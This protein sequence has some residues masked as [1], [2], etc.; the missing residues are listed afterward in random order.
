MESVE[1]L[2]AL[3]HLIGFAEIQ[4]LFDLTCT[5]CRNHY[6]DGYT[7]RCKECISCQCIKERKWDRDSCYSHHYVGTSACEKISINPFCQKN[8]Q[9]IQ[10]MHALG[11]NLNGTPTT[12]WTKEDYDA[13]MTKLGKMTETERQQFANEF[14][15]VCNGWFTRSAGDFISRTQ[16]QGM[17]YE[18]GE[19]FKKYEKKAIEK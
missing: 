6:H 1:K 18:L 10:T 8:Q 17:G 13:Y 11:M 16:A 2:K 14:F 19:A 15:P 5:D 9:A 12:G 3:Q 7:Y 4:R